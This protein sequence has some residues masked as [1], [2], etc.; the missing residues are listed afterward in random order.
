VKFEFLF[1]KSV[2][3]VPVSLKC[4]EKTGYFTKRPIH[5]FYHIS[6]IFLELFQTKGVENIKTHILYSVT[7][8][9]KSCHLLGNAEKFCRGRQAKDDNMARAHCMVDT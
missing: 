7:F 5:I 2:K 1:W 6:L 3:K 9:R 8:F 4:D